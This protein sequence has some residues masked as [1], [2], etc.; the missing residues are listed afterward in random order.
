MPADQ[1]KDLECRSCGTDVSQAPRWK[2]FNNEYLCEICFPRW[3][4][5]IELQSL[6]CC[7]YCRDTVARCNC[8]KNRYG[9]YI[10]RKCS[11]AGRRESRKVWL[12]RAS[13]RVRRWIGYG[14]AAAIA[15][16]FVYKAF[17][18]AAGRM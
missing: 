15:A 14:F 2:N 4:G 3:T 8:H 11:D 6:R 1:T 13:R 17:S 7:A 10:C 9:E 5:R 12:K 18:M 16:A